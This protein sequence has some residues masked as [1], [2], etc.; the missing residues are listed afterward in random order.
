MRTTMLTMPTAGMPLLFLFARRGEM[1]V[2]PDKN[3][4][5]HTAATGTLGARDLIRRRRLYT[6]TTPGKS[7]PGH[8]AA[9]AV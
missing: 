3:H 4:S 5:G 2:T 1:R 7:H 6:T 9:A 8:T